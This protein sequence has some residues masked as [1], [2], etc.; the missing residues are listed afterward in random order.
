LSIF[1]FNLRYTSGSS[2]ST[3]EDKSSEREKPD[4]KP[5]CFPV[6]PPELHSVVCEWLLKCLADPVQEEYICQD[7]GGFSFVLEI[8]RQSLRTPLQRPSL[9][10]PSNVK[11]IVAV[12]SRWAAHLPSTLPRSGGSRPPEVVMQNFQGALQTSFDSFLHVFSP[13]VMRLHN[14]IELSSRQQKDAQVDQQ[15][16]ITR[17][18]QFFTEL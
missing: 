1:Y 9:D 17:I 13:H 12:F 4:E 18:V 10:K 11:G 15:E 3:G 7:D 2:Q 6:C 5:W 16:L 14:K 8:F